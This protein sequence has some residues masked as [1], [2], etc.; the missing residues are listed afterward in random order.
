VA[1][2]YGT[3]VS[4][5]I[6]NINLFHL[7]VLSNKQGSRCSLGILCVKPFGKNYP[8]ICIGAIAI[9]KE[10]FLFTL[11]WC[12]IPCWE[13]LAHVTIFNCWKQRGRGIDW[14]YHLSVPMKRDIEIDQ[15]NDSNSVD[16][17]SSSICRCCCCYSSSEQSFLSSVSLPT[18]THKH[19]I[20]YVGHQVHVSS[21]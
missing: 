18:A 13:V 1:V 17:R 19:C 5:T 6:E 8:P 21:L 16:S 20:R 9:C 7:Q 4:R 2:P 15:H 14:W 11:L 3:S 10:N 12:F